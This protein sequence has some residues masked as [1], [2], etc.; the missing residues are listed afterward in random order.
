MAWLPEMRIKHKRPAGS[1]PLRSQ[2][3]DQPESEQPV[4]DQVQIV[5]VAES[6]YGLYIANLHL[7]SQF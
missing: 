2:P 3:G 7:I 6:V 5:L 1:A 4:T